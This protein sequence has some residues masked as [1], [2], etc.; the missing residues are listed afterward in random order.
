MHLDNAQDLDAVTL[1]HNLIEYSDKYYL[2]NQE[3]SI[4]KR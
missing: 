3:L 2:K 1:M 4:L